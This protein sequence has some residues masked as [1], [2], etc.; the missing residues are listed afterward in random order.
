MTVAPSPVAADRAAVWRP[1]VT[2]ATVVERDG[3]YLLVEE[4]VRG[5]LVVN[6][7][8]GHLEAGESLHDAALRETREET[9]WLVELEALVAV[10]QWTSPDDGSAYVR[11]TFAAR[12][13]EPIPDACLDHGIERVLWLT[14]EEL[15][16]GPFRV[17]SPLVHESIADHRAGRRAPLDSL[18]LVPSL[19]R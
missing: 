16:D 4:R 14:P 8:A 3:R 15:R 1:D 11:F 13:I 12:A 10:Y 6:Q 2:V 9:G 7:P 5:V 18:R 17:R 19:P